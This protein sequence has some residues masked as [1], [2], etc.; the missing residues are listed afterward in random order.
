MQVPYLVRYPDR[1]EG[2]RRIDGLIDV[3]IDT[4]VTLLDLAGA[5]PF[6]AAHGVSYRELVEGTAS[7]TRD[8]VM[9][10]TFRM[11][12]GAKGEYT[13]VPERG[14][15]TR[16]W[17]YVRQP[18]RRKML[19]DQKA[20]PHELHNLIDDPRYAALMADFDAQILA[21]MQATGDDWDLHLD[22]PPPDFLTHGEAA[23]HLKNDLLPRAIL[24]P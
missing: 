19:F 3:G 20:D 11:N 18:N 17:L 4:P 2:G 14:I 15:R 24:V 23:A 1:V 7:S 12:G 16:D 22:F 5:Q 13:P 6:N 8:A 10:Q 21:H 9:Y